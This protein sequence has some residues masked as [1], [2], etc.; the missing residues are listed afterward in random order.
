MSWLSDKR[1]AIILSLG[2]KWL[3]GKIESLRKE[4]GAVGK[5]L[6]GNK[7]RLSVAIMVAA[8]FVG[9]LTGTDYKTIAQG[10]I[11]AVGGTDTE[12]LWATVTVVCGHLW[13]VYL[14]FDSW[15]KA[16]AQV[17]AGAALSE[18]NS[19]KGII[20]AEV[21][22]ATKEED[23]E[24]KWEKV[25]EIPEIKALPKVADTR[26]TPDPV[27]QASTGLTD[28][29]SKALFTVGSRILLQDG[30]EA[31]VMVTKESSGNGFTYGVK[32]L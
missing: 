8:V 27:A 18:V 30:R 16:R 12:A 6:D 11:A 21:D 19:P 3:R 15:R 28:I 22:K 13:G 9:L 31:V 4:G 25:G 5:F 7:N 20:M 29:R 1:D 24:L 26:I 10:L 23:V 14:V 32:I 2:L 17:K